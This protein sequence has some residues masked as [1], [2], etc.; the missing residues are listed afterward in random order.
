[1]VFDTTQ[2][3]STLSEEHCNL[4]RDNHPILEHKRFRIEDGVLQVCHE[5]LH[6]VIQGGEE[7]KIWKVVTIS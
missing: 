6:A 2:E 5:L 7:D 4:R 3:L 1:M